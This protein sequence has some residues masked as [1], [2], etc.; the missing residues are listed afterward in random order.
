M[1]HSGAMTATR[2]QIGSIVALPAASLVIARALY[3]AVCY[4]TATYNSDRCKASTR[5]PGRAH[6]LTVFIQ[7][8]Y[9]FIFNLFITLGVPVVLDALCKSKFGPYYGP[10]SDL[11]ADYVV[12]NARFQV[13][14]QIGCAPAL[15]ASGLTILLLTSGPISL[16]TVPAAFYTCT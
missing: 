5:P 2:I 8:K 7:L 11:R 15:Q 1:T 10:T 12:Q 4:Q 9:E 13:V 14:E 16:L 6:K 3:R